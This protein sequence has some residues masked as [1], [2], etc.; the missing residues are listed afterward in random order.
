MRKVFM[1]VAVLAAIVIP[2]ASQAQDSK[3]ILGFRLGYAP[4]MGDAMQGQSMKDAM[5][6][7]IPIQ[8]DAL[9]KF[10]PE[11]AAGMYFS[12]GFGQLSSTEA[13]ACDAMGVDCSMSSVRVGVEGTYTFTTASPTFVPW[14]GAG[15]GYEAVSETVAVSGVSASQDTSGWE[16]LNLQLGGD[17]KV[18]PSFAIGP[19]VMYSI[20]QYSSI[21][22]NSIPETATHEWLNV[23][24]RGKFD[25]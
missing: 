5:P 13:D 9:Y 14:I 2:T 24:V 19:Y 6:S 8:L 16:F 23:G 7:Q 21:G 4:A 20:G 1:L 10:T 11:W 18:S 15:F 12:Y 22:G 25:L 17:W 3:W